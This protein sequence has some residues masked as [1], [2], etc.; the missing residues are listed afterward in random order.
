ML[1]LTD[2]IFRRWAKS[3]SRV[4]LALEEGASGTRLTGCSDLRTLLLDED[5]RLL[6]RAHLDSKPVLLSQQRRRVLRRDLN[7]FINV[8]RLNNEETP[9]CS[10]VSTKAPS[11]TQE[12]PFL[13]RIDFAQ[14]LLTSPASAITLPVA[15][16]VRQ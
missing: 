3:P 7:R 10:L 5:I 16:M 15:R 9:S 13:G 6:N 8:C 11:V 2:K 12:R 1:G 14:R 4:P